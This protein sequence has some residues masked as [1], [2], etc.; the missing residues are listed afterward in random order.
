MKLEIPQMINLE[1]KTEDL[2]LSARRKMHFDV[3]EVSR[4]WSC[5]KATGTRSPEA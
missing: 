2:A 3:F 1:K 5:E 4:Y